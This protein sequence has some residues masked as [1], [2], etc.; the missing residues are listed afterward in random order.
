MNRRLFLS[1]KIILAASLLY[2]L[3]WLATA[4][5]AMAPVQA[6]VIEKVKVNS[7]VSGLTGPAGSPLVPHNYKIS[8][9]AIAPFIVR[10]D[11]SFNCHPDMCDYGHSELSFWLPGLVYRFRVITWWI[12]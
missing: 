5:F 7:S 11:L 6:F 8:T 1:I 9:T 2:M 3:L 12:S 10:A 4:S